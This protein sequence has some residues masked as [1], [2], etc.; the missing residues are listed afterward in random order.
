MIEVI[1]AALCIYAVSSLVVNYDGAFG[2]FERIRRVN[3]LQGVTS[4][5]VCASFWMSIPFL[6]IITPLEV[7]AAYGLVILAVRYE[8]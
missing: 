8:P 4:C 7:L 1:I 6:F 5:A 3:A 2:I